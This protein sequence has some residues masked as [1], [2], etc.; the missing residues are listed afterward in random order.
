M[1]FNV[2]ING[3]VLTAMS[4]ADIEQRAAAWIRSGAAVEVE[5]QGSTGFVPLHQFLAAPA[6]APAITPTDFDSTS[7][8]VR[9][10]GQVL[11][12]YERQE[13]EKRAAR[14]QQAGVDFEIAEAGTSSFASPAVVF[15]RART[16]ATFAQSA[17]VPAQSAPV[18]QPSSPVPHFGAGPY[19][20][21]V[22]GQ[23]LGPLSREEIET[24]S[25]RWPA[26]VIE[27]AENP[28]GAYVE[29]AAFLRMPQPVPV[30]AAQAIPAPT[31]QAA[32][33]HPVVPVRHPATA[34]A[35]TLVTLNIYWLFWLA[36]TFKRIRQLNPSATNITPGKAVGFLFIPLFGPLW[37][38]WIAFSLPQA[39]ACA[40]SSGKSG[41]GFASIAAGLM[42]LV[43][44]LWI[45]GLAFTGVPAR[46]A[47][48]AGCEALFLGFIAYCQAMLNSAACAVAGIPARGRPEIVMAGAAGFAA[49]CALVGAFF[50]Y[51]STPR[52]ITPILEGVHRL[53]GE[54]NFEAA[55]RELEQVNAPAAK[56]E[57]AFLYKNGLGVP[58]DS[59]KAVAVLRE[60]AEAGMAD[61]Q[62]TL[63]S[64]YASGDGVSEDPATAVSWY[65]RAAAQGDNNGAILL[66]LAYGAGSGVEQDV[67]K[68]YMWF[69]VAAN[70]GDPYAAS[71]KSVT[72]NVL[73]D[74][75]R[76][77]AESEAAAEVEREKSGG[78]REN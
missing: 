48:I 38:V 16:N 71:Q 58:Q 37:F 32:G 54:G 65:R 27:V 33:V 56:Y 55:A 60:A 59:G 20:V 10:N 69:T 28:R 25:Q 68:A 66:G 77:T 62:T 30:P 22:D 44:S 76:A 35:L 8:I 75:Q 50:S 74:D 13:V 29:L 43:G 47:W 41:Y 51:A 21:R 9:V 15:G 14:W 57:L 6:H 40:R 67:Q 1:T 78:S 7:Y 73:S 17:A 26:T 11:G 70:R 52:D 18:V 2:R 72:A 45:F 24:R 4:R 53:A 19:W 46:I 31:V 5:E 3:Q 36:S 39:T 23:L 49:V 34:V 42:C 63:G 12:P 61:A 64:W